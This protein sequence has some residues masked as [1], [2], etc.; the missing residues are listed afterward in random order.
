MPANGSAIPHPVSLTHS[1][2]STDSSLP[3]ST[4]AA[5]AFKH[6]LRLPK[7][8]EEWEEANSLLQSSVVPAVLQ[9]ISAEEKNS[10]LSDG[11]YE[12]LENSFSTRSPPHSQRKAEVK[13][14]QHNRALEEVN[15]RK[16]AAK[17]VFCRAKGLG[18]S[19]STIQALAATFLLLL[20]DHT[21]A[22]ASR[23]SQMEAKMA[24]KQ[25][26]QD[27]WGYAKGLFDNSGTSGVSPGFSASSAH[28]FFTDVY[29]ATSHHHLQTPTWMS[30]PPDPH[31]MMDLTPISAEELVQVIRKAR[32]SS[33][34]SP[35]DCI[36]YLTIKRCPSL[37][38][39]ILDLINRVIMEG[40]VP[41][42]W[43]AAVVKAYS[44]ECC[45]K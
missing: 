19:V 45:Q 18:E 10:L 40:R 25:C 20:R 39:A 17:Q 37:H 29:R 9:A 36:S 22:S 1:G 15:R 6:P 23:L 28:T 42:K 16:N 35:L 21:K 3:Q 11:T 5:H 4:A 41:S 8:T 24:R 32:V 14:R 30:A 44:Q 34:P 43:K 27:F 31:S 7:T 12:V 38:P 33:C 2:Q 26:H 13:L